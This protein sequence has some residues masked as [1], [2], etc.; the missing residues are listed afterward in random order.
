MGKARTLVGWL[1]TL[2]YLF[3]VVTAAREEQ[4]TAS[5]MLSFLERRFPDLSPEQLQTVV[6]VI[7]KAIHVTAYGVLALFCYYGSVGTRVLKRA[8]FLS[9]LFLA[10]IVAGLDEFI[11]TFQNGRTGALADVAIDGVGI[12]LALLLLRILQGRKQPTGL[13]D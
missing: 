9:A 6:F 3:M 2:G 11:Q 1:G 12:A 10:L 8:P 5:F 7:R 13:K 4:F